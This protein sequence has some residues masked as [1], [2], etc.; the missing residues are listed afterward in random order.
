MVIAIILQTDIEISETPPNSEMLNEEEEM[1]NEEEKVRIED[2]NLDETSCVI[3]NWSSLLNADLDT[4]IP[5]YD[6]VSTSKEKEQTESEVK[7]ELEGIY[8]NYIL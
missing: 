2:V 4:L 6:S 3:R 5:E 1:L 7:L 8:L